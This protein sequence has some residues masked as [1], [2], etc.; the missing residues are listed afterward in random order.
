[1]ERSQFISCIEETKKLTGIDLSIDSIDTERIIKVAIIGQP[2]QNIMGF[3]SRIIPDA[4]PLNRY[5]HRPYKCS[6]GFSQDLSVFY[7]EDNS[8]SFDEIAQMLTGFEN[9]SKGRLSFKINADDK[10]LN[11]VQIDIITSDSEYDDIDFNELMCEYEQIYF[12]LTA[13]ALLSLTERRVLKNK[14]LKYAPQNLNIL[15]TADD[16]IL[17]EDRADIDKLLNSFF[18]GNVKI[19]RLPNA[20]EDKLAE[21]IGSLAEDKERLRD[22]LEQRRERLTLEEALSAVSLHKTFL[23]ND[24]EKLD[25]AIEVL[26]YKRGTL[27]AQTEK[28]QRT[29]KMRYSSKLKLDMSAAISDFY[30]AITDKLHKEIDDTDDILTARDSLPD[31]IKT[32]WE[33]FADMT[34]EEAVNTFN[35]MGK[36]VEEYLGKELEK[37]IEDGEEKGFFDYISSIAMN[38]LIRPS[39][40][41]DLKMTDTISSR[42]IKNNAG[43]KR[44][45]AVAAGLVLTVIA[46][47]LIGIPVAFGGAK[48]LGDNEERKFISQ[49][50]TALKKDSDN[51]N[52]EMFDLMLSGFDREMLEAENKLSEYV[53]EFYEKI[54]DELSRVL[55]E[56][57]QKKELR[58]DELERLCRN[59]ME[60]EKLLSNYKTEE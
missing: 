30:Y 9:S 16:L 7:G 38:Y 22:A 39:L 20:D 10:L 25:E 29:V 47:P 45:G 49:T 37:Y 52:R 3:L 53:K 4:L 55:E 48:I 5:F 58:E 50:K 28:S 42:E 31:Y 13:T 44:I 12:S 27:P 18:G 57:K 23:E 21:D 51:M 24:G 19:Y 17:S 36:S 46:N 11:K 34:M 35:E 8:S 2:Q 60:I 59:E 6:V 41:E 15:L 1:M 54:M 33:R 40:G 14:L 32:Q 26:K 56:H 43:K